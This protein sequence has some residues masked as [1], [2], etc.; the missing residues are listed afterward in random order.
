M[1]RSKR[2][3]CRR[4]RIS[5]LFPCSPIC[6]LS[7]RK[8]NDNGLYVLVEWLTFVFGGAGGPGMLQNLRRLGYVVE[9]VWW[10]SSVC[11]I[12]VAGLS[13]VDEA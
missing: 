11:F 2:V 12:R 9:D 13:I 8:R 6:L 5:Y 10:W 4:V 3:G 7:S 1:E